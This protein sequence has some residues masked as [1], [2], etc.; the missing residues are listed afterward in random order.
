MEWFIKRKVLN[1]LYQSTALLITVLLR[2]F[3]ISIFKLSE[4]FSLPEGGGA[5]NYVDEIKSLASLWVS[6]LRW[7][8]LSVLLSII[9]I[10]ISIV[11]KSF[12]KK[13][14]GIN[15]MDPAL[16]ITLEEKNSAYFHPSVPLVNL[17]SL[18]QMSEIFPKLIKF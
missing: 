13:S 9:R 17:I 11:F 16:I 2:I 10:T 7:V 6:E 8:E 12:V 14:A 1:K 3:N 4:R 15:L 18:R 5:R